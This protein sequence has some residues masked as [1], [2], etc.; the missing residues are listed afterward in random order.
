MDFEFKTLTHELKN[1]VYF[2]ILTLQRGIKHFVQ[3]IINKVCLIKN[4]KLDVHSFKDRIMNGRCQCKL[5]SERK[6]YC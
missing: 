5:N 2:T 6:E 1:I 4:P 3:V